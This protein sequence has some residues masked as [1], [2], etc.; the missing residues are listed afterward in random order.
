MGDK[1]FLTHHTVHVL[2]TFTRK[3]LTMLVFY[4]LG[5]KVVRLLQFLRQLV[6]QL[7]IASKRWRTTKCQADTNC[8]P[9][10]QSTCSK[11]AFHTINLMS[12]SLS[13]F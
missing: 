10:R 12:Y 9:T 6:P 1:I 4:T 2:L 13:H 8:F 5:F 3:V 11:R 7:E